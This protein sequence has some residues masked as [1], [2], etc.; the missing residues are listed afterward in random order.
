MNRRLEQF[1]AAENISQSE[2]ADTIGV[3]RASVSH[4]LAGRNKPSYDFITGMMAHYPRLNTEWLLAG[5][6]KMYKDPLAIRPEPVEEPAEQ[7]PDLFSV[8][9]QEE[10]IAVP[11]AAI[12][13]N[14]PA[15]EGN[16][17]QPQLSQPTDTQRKIT[18]IIVF[19]DDNTFQELS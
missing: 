16:P 10:P 3:A 7:E 9:P 11:Q 14:T 19:Y 1:L 15:S 18:K 8:T 6:G 13:A 12:P 4:I 5:K 17:P 2:F